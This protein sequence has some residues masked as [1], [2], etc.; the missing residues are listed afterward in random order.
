MVCEAGAR[1]IECL[2]WGHFFHTAIRM[3]RGP[4]GAD[5]VRGSCPPKSRHVRR[6]FCAPSRCWSRHLLAPSACPEA[7]GRGICSH[8]GPAAADGVRECRPQQRQACAE[9]GRDIW[10]H[11]GTRHVWSRLCASQVYGRDSPLGVGE[12]QK[13]GEGRG[14]HPGPWHVLVPCFLGLG[15]SHRSFA[16]EPL[17]E[18]GVEFRRLG[19]GLVGW[20][21]SAMPCHAMD[22]SV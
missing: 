8:D 10:A 12:G 5:G 13:R 21:R 11:Q 9:A 17:P 16:G 14:A 2:K 1:S 6:Q 7:S 22:A 20:G 18:V 3:H 4:A 19:K 15:H